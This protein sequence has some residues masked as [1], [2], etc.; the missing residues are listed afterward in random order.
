MLIIIHGNN[1]DNFYDREVKTVLNVCNGYARFY[2]ESQQLELTRHLPFQLN[3]FRQFWLL[4]FHVYYEG[5]EK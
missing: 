2:N 3:V 1:A 5:M 4:C